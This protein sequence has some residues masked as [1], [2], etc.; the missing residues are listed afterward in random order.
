MEKNK[1]MKDK[2]IGLKINTLNNIKNQIQNYIIENLEKK[3]EKSKSE[4]K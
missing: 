3:S 2:E 1:I 4:K